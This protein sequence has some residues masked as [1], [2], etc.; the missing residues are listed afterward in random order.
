ML[1]EVIT[2]GYPVLRAMLFHHPKD[3]M[4]WHIDDQYYFG[5][6][7]LVAP[8]MNSDN[9]RNVYLP[10]GDWVNLFT[11][12]VFEGKQWLNDFECPLDEMPVWVKKG[13]SI[14][15]YPFHV[16]NTD[17]NNFV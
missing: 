11:G 16:S 13:A 9:K 10:E 1:Y 6:D 12:E 5:D 17:R 7:F 3:K 14:S 15:V 2:S 4:C 8:V